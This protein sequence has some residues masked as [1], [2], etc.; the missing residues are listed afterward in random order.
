MLQTPAMPR[1][2]ALVP[3]Q[4]SGASEQCRMSHDAKSKQELT[5]IKD[6][7]AVKVIAAPFLQLFEPGPL[8]ST[9]RGQAGRRADGQ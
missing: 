1:N 7:E 3:L 2:G 9:I 8:Q 4:G 6:D 5:L